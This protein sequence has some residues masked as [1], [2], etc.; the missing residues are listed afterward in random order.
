[1]GVHIQMSKY[2]KHRVVI[3]RSIFWRPIPAIWGV[4]W[5]LI[6]GFH[7][8]REELSPEVREKWRIVNM[9]PSWTW[10]TWTIIFLL[11][12]ILIILEG[13]YRLVVQKEKEFIDQL[14]IVQAERD[15]LYKKLHKDEVFMPLKEAVQQLYDKCINRPRCKRFIDAHIKGKNTLPQE[16]WENLAPYFF[17][18][19][20]VSVWGKDVISGKMIEV[21]LDENSLNNMYF[22]DNVSSLQIL[23]GD[24]QE[25]TDLSIKRDEVDKAINEIIMEREEH[26]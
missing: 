19:T 6:E 26:Y 22:G 11:G 9:I 23:I 25:Y 21:K 14:N 4:L 12:F 24:H 1:M 7:I 10:Q 20:T 17:L 18:S 8:I 15:Q 5:L 3:W 16:V 13:A 2:L